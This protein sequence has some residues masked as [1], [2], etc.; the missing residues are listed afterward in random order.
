VD[1]FRPRPL[2][3]RE[4]SRR[5]PLDS[6]LGGPQNRS[7]RGGEEKKSSP[8]PELNPGRPAR[9]RPELEFYDRNIKLIEGYIFSD[10]NMP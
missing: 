10:E 6:R 2:Y 1:S 7:G 9:E 5:Y 4:E 8:L 3:P